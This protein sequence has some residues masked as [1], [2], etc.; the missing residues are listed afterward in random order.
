MEYKGKYNSPIGEL[1]IVSNDHYIQEICFA[2]NGKNEPFEEKLNSLIV[3]TM[4]QLNAYFAKLI[5]SFDL[6]LFPLGSAFQKEV[7]QI[8]AKIPYGTTYSYKDIAMRLGDEKK[9]RAIGMASGQ[10]PIPIIIP[11]HRVIGSDGSLTGY[12]G[13][14]W[15]KDW[16][17]KHEF[18]EF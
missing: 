7:W 8:I 6:P 13:G 5:S 14:V 17:L 18:A 4:E 11:C 9:A 1:I 2:D 12:A 10:N 15:R 3:E 16:L